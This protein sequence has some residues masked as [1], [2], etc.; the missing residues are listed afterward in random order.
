MQIDLYRHLNSS[1]GSF[2][3]FDCF[4]ASGWA[5]HEEIAVGASCPYRDH[6]HQSSEAGHELVLFLDPNPLSRFRLPI[7][8]QIRVLAR[9][10]LWYGHASPCRSYSPVNG[11]NSS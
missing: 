6:Q 4:R 3:A 8:K 5:F 1:P 7:R 11:W 10:N 9:N 2:L